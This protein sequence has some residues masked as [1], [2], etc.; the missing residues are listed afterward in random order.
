MNT[1]MRAATRMGQDRKVTVRR[2]G[3]GRRRNRVKTPGLS[4]GARYLRGFVIRLLAF[5][6]LTRANDLASCRTR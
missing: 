6:A 1:K 5:S 3:I 4:S 2:S